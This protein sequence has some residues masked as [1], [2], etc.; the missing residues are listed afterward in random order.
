MRRLL[1]AALALLFCALF[2]SGAL[3]LAPLMVLFARDRLRAHGLVRGLW[4]SFVWGAS[5]VRL[6]R[7]ERG[8]LSDVS[9]AVIVANHPS[10]IDVVILVALMPKTLYVAKRQLLRSF[11]LSFAVRATAL[12]DD[13]QLLEVAPAYLAAGWNVLIFPEGTRSPEPPSPRPF[14]R[15]AAQLALRTHAPIL[16]VTMNL[17]RRLL[18]KGQPV[19]DMG[20]ERVVYSLT[21]HPPRVPERR[22]S[23][24][25]HEAAVRVTREM[26]ETILLSV[27]HKLTR[28][29]TNVVAT[30]CG[31]VLSVF[32]PVSEQPISG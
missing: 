18:A 7:V 12:P 24:S 31:R 9:G 19:W 10:L 23:E 20:T 25:L 32:L 16:C 13:A 17:S 14:H 11:P 6:I 8:N 3:L 22:P 21:A 2:V 27:S 29:D 1:R 26:E 28:M 4:R 15:G 30:H 5:A